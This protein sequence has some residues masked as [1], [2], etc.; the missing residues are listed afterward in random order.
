MALVRNSSKLRLT[1][2]AVFL[3]TVAGTIT[4]LYY[5]GNPDMQMDSA[6]GFGGFIVAV[7]AAYLGANAAIHYKRMGREN[8]NVDVLGHGDYTPP[9]VVAEGEIEVEKPLEDKKHIDIDLRR[10]P[11]TRDYTEGV[12]TFSIGNMVMR[13]DSLE[14]EKR[15]LKVHG[16]TRIPNGKYKVEFNQT[17]TPLTQ[18]Y[19]DRFPNWFTYHL[20]IKD[21][22]NFTG[23]YFH[24]G[25]DSDDSAGCI[26]LGKKTSE[27]Y[28]S[29]SA[30]TYEKVYKAL[31][32]ELEKGNTITV[33]I[34][35]D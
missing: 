8:P 23:I 6:L 12:M 18:K 26:L 15:E 2:S 5:E 21:V 24:I 33:N 7:V 31:S 11:S 22:P 3:F 19:R 1:Y 27:G 28:I 20:H 17:V 4:F 9:V 35:E 29:D 10:K 16:E 13:V 25:N 30:R 34:H 14:D 32:S